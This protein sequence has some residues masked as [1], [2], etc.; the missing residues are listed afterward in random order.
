MQKRVVRWG[1][2]LLLALAAMPGRAQSLVPATYKAPQA[3]ARFLPLSEVR[4]GLKGTAYTVFAGT[5]PEPFGVEVIGVIPGYPEPGQAFIV[6]RLSGANAERTSVFGG[7][8]GSPVYV[9]GRLMGAIS[10]SFPF[11]K[12]PIAGITPI[13][14]MLDNFATEA[15]SQ[16]R[17]GPREVGPVSFTQLASTDWRADWP[18]AQSNSGTFVMPAATNPMLSPVAGQMVQPITTPLV[19]SGLSQSTLSLFAGPLAAHNLQPVASV[20]GAASLQPLA[21]YDSGTL[22]P[23][24]SVSVQLVRGDYSFAAAGT[25][26]FRDGDRIYAFGHPF[27]NVG[28]AD[29]PMV[30]SSVVTVIPNLNNS[31]KLAVEGRMVGSI[32][33]DR[34]SGVYGQLGRAPKMI[35]VRV[36][37]YNSRGRTETFNYEVASDPALT[38]ILLQIT[39]YS[40]LTSSERNFG[41]ATFSLNGKIDVAGQ[42]PVMM[43]RR[44]SNGNSAQGLAG[45]VASTVAT[46]MTTG[47][48]NVRLNG[49]TLDITASEERAV[50]TLERIEVDKNE[51][52]RGEM[53]EVRACARTISGQQF[54]QRIPLRV[55]SD[56][57]LGELTLGL[58]DGAAVQQKSAAQAFVPR[59]LKQL[60]SAINRVRKNDRLYLK[61]YTP[62]RGAVIAA[63]EMPNLP[64]SMLATLGND[65]NAGGYT[66]TNVSPVFEQEIPP[67]DFIITGQQVISLQ[68]VR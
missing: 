14:Q 28:A 68:V 58:G 36:N 34:A 15:S 11:S 20:G 41:M 21:P 54:M 43:E 30:E 35:P 23:G 6:A 26:T 46:L 19:Y 55:P 48:D 27:L 61:L 57:P 4:A 59:D 52:G 45:S 65:R 39:L 10:H 22:K 42:T 51:I 49:I 53:L 16:Q 24:R 13:E 5:E 63:N 18:N 33:Q 1:F 50:A 38:P 17:R 40:S 56:V 67:A 62:N 9:N 31:F 3:D 25:V 12:E 47:F 60:V 2:W 66:P 29:M 64:P 37:L 32:T 8:S 44:V 7:M